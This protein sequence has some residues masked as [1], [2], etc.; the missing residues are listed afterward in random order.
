MT[1]CK[2]II[3]ILSILI[4]LCSFASKKTTQG[5][6]IGIDPTWYPLELTGRET[7]VLAFSIELLQEIAKKEDLQLSIVTM[8]WN[9]LIWGL[10]KKKYD[11]ILSS[12]YPYVFYEKK[13]HFSNVYLSTGPVIV[14]PEQSKIKK[15][16]D[17]KGKTVG[18]LQGSAASV[19]LQKYPGL[20]M[21]SYD[22]MPE[23]LNALEN[24]H[25]DA[26]VLDSL[27]AQSYVRDLYADK[28]K[29]STPP[30]NEQ[31]LRLI[32]LDT[33]K[34]IL[35]EKFNAGLKKLQKN[36]RYEELLKKWGLSDS[37]PTADV[38]QNIELF[39]KSFPL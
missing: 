8:N 2:N 39:L 30:L 19:F 33:K 14:V 18:I 7:N 29:I 16:D 24:M 32:M 31:G 37:K 1:K 17:L 26:A 25:I 35:I 23:T 28:L 3:F 36:G 34:Q 20:L 9:N 6:Q 22:T 11:A 15:L 5:Y 13:F 21:Q 10:T 27:S 12:L 38:E 4:I